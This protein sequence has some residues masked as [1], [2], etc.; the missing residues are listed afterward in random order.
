MLEE[1]GIFFEELQQLA[2][3]QTFDPFD[4]ICHIAFDKPALTRSERVKKVQK[5]SLFSK[6]GEQAKEVIEMLLAKYADQGIEVIENI[7]IL[8]VSPFSD[9]RTPYQVLN[10]IF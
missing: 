7:N 6:Y 9:K 8:K 1:K 3:N 5:E 10:N 2:G 4:L